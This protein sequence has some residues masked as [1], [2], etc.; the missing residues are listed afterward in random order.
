MLG[1]H[2]RDIYFS[3]RLTLSLQVLVDQNAG[4]RVSDLKLRGVP[5]LRGDVAAYVS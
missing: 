5:T 2:E 1:T 4:T 3:T